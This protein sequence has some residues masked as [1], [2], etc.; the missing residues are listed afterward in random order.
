M[1]IALACRILSAGESMERVPQWLHVALPLSYT[2]YG[3][4]VMYKV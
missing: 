1:D 3:I 4:L 2:N